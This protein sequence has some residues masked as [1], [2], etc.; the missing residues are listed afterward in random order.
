MGAMDLHRAHLF[1][2]CLG[3]DMGLVFLLATLQHQVPPHA[4]TQMP[5]LAHNSSPIPDISEEGIEKLIAKI[6]VL[7]DKKEEDEAKR[8]A[9][10]QMAPPK[11]KTHYPKGGRILSLDPRPL[12]SLD[13]IPMLALKPRPILAVE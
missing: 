1:T 13:P 4:A 11:E 7:Q 12:L 5:P 3:Q 9:K 8:A 2:Q 6:K 10:H